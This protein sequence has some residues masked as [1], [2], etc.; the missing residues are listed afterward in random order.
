MYIY[1]IYIY[2]IYILFGFWMPQAQYRK[3]KNQE[4]E[5]QKWLGQKHVLREEAKRIGVSFSLKE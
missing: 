3:H 2:K 4:M 1:I 5:I